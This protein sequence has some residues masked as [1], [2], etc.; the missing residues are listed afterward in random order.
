MQLCRILEIHCKDKLINDSFLSQVYIRSIEA[1]QC[2]HEGEPLLFIYATPNPWT[3][4]LLISFWEMII[5]NNGDGG[6]TNFVEGNL[7]TSLAHDRS[8]WKMS[9]WVGHD[10]TLTIKITQTPCLCSGGVH[11]FAI[12]I[13]LP[14]L[15][16]SC[17][18]WAI[19][20]GS[21]TCPI[22]SHESIVEASHPQW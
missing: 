22:L 20:C 10:K 4:L 12:S 18:I 11:H 15:A 19:V 6:K 5:P 14:C 9:I 16:N 8:N 21:H 17:P 3:T 2:S 7:F 13:S 1:A